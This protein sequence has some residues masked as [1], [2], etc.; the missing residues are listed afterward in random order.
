MFKLVVVLMLI[1]V[2]AS[3]FSGL[4][5]L[6]RDQGAGDRTVKALTVRIGLSIAVFALLLL[7]YRFGLIPG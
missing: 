4:F 1:G 2:I 7:G 3:L 6:F 5:F